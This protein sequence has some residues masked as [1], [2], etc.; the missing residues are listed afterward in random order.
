MCFVEG[1]KMQEN[2]QFK[3]QLCEEILR[4]ES[5]KKTLEERL[6]DAPSGTLRIQKTGS[7]NYT[8]YYVADSTNVRKYLPKNQFNT[9]EF[10]S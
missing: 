9:R 6:Q 2:T 10:D 5:L 7:G 8:Q 4:L 1:E 3:R